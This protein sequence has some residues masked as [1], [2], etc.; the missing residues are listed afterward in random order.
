MR[1]RG[2][3]IAAALAGVLGSLAAPSPARAQDDEPAAV[4]PPDTGVP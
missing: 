1:F 3:F 4:A 2:A